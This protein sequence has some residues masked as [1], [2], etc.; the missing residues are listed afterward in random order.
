MCVCVSERFSLLLWATL[1]DD[2]EQLVLNKGFILCYYVLF[3]IDLKNLFS[4][5]SVQFTLS[6]ISHALK[7]YV[8]DKSG[9]KQ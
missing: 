7:L 4:W 1:M 5:G 3:L 6:G 2:V 8:Y 9:V